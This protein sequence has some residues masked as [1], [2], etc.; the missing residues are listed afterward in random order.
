MWAQLHVQHCIKPYYHGHHLA[1]FPVGFPGLSLPSG[2]NIVHQ[3]IWINHSIRGMLI[4]GATALWQLL[5]WWICSSY[6]ECFQWTHSVT[7]LEAC[8]CCGSAVRGRVSPLT[9]LCFLTKAQTL[10]GPWRQTGPPDLTVQTAL[11]GCGESCI[12]L[13]LNNT[14]SATTLL[15]SDNCFSLATTGFRSHKRKQPCH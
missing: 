8:V 10:T 15:V 11:G 7:P 1:L 13:T 4:S 14:G 3:V 5:P 2:I 12:C 6:S 9:V